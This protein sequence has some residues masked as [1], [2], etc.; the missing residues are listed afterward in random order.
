[1][2]P[3]C[4]AQ[5]ASAVS[6]GRKLVFAGVSSRRKLVPRRVVRPWQLLSVSYGRKLVCFRGLLQAG[7][8][9]SGRKRVYHGAVKPWQLLSVSSGKK[10]AFHGAVRPHCT[11]QQASAASFG[12]KLVFPMECKGLL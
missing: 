10:L 4:I 3:P 11:A 7:A 9:S 2:R 12:R 1:M 6:S 8:V 5:Q